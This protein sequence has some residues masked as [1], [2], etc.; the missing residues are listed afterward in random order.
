MDLGFNIVV[1][2]CL[3]FVLVNKCFTIVASKTKPVTTNKGE[4]FLMYDVCNTQPKELKSNKK[5]G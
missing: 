4:I 3:I 5:K 1:L 2:M